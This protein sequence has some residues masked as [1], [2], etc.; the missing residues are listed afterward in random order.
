MTH[1]KNSSSERDIPDPKTH[2]V[3]NLMRR[4]KAGDSAAEAHLKEWIYEQIIEVCRGRMKRENSS[5]TWRTSDLVQEVYLRMA[6]HKSFAGLNLAK[7]DRLYLFAAIAKSMRRVLVDR[8]RER[9][10]LKRGRE[11]KR[12]PLD[13]FL[14]DFVRVEAL[15][16]LTLD[17]ALV[18]LASLDPRQ[19]DII[20]LRFFGGFTVQEVADELGVSKSLVEQDWQAARAWLFDRLRGDK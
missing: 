10:T 5:H 12:E 3:T 19:A 11:W 1:N 20:E 15:D 16:L 6:G 8:A 18:V 14:E 2:H 13:S 7:A 9:S 4:A 17:E